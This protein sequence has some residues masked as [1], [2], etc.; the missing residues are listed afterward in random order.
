MLFYTKTPYSTFRSKGIVT[1]LFSIFK[2]TFIFHFYKM[3][4]KQIIFKIT[5]I[6]KNIRNITYI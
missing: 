2:F 4:E 3:K 1:I 6:I 5:L